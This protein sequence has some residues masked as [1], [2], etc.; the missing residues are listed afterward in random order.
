[1]IRRFRL[2]R[3]IEELTVWYSR[4]VSPVSLVAGF[5]AD[6]LFLAKR[7]DLFLTNAILFTYL[8]VSAVCII[9]INLIQEGYIR[10]PR[11]VKSLP[12]FLVAVQFAFGGLFSAYLSLYSRS[13]NIAVSWIFVIGIAAL[14]LANERFSHFYA[15]FFVQIGIYFTVLFSFLTFFL[16]VVFH[17]IGPVMFL[18]SGALALA[19][20]AAFLAAL[21]GISK[22]RSGKYRAFVLV[23]SIYLVFNVLYFTNAIPPLPLALKSGGVY[24]DIERQ[25]DGSYTLAGEKLPWY[26]QY[27]NYTPVYHRAPGEPVFVWSAIFAPSG[28][29]TTVLHRWQ[30]YSA[31]QK[32]WVTESEITFPIYGGRDG[33]YRGYSEILSAEPGAWRVDVLT[34]YG[35]LIGR[36]SFT[37]VDASTTASLVASTQ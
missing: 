11:W 3:S 20:M 28:L 21:L 15:R 25:I 30:W 26:E 36:I 32:Q 23:G 31:S 19:V 2:P 4:Y 14:V 9:L 16:P 27:L 7:V 10:R 35:A 12:I 17:T 29:S 1:M 5:L 6:N 8:V 37:V 22:N 33:G 34:S 24:H 13:A 18:W